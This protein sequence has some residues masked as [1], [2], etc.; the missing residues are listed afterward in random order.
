[1]QHIP[2]KLRSE[3]Q[4]R[5]GLPP[6]P[7]ALPGTPRKE[8]MAGLPQ[9]SCTGGGGQF[10]LEGSPPL[11]GSGPAGLQPAATVSKTVL[12][13]PGRRLARDIFFFFWVTLSRPNCRVLFKQPATNI[14]LTRSL[15]D[16][17]WKLFVLQPWVLAFE[18]CITKGC[19]GQRWRGE[20]SMWGAGGHSQGDHEP[21]P[22]PCKGVMLH[23]SFLPL[24]ST[25]GAAATVSVPPHR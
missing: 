2:S 5:Q 20:G 4:G 19:G 15:W 25:A 18:Q 6:V 22:R 13:W 1:M 16:E 24:L 9:G 3:A 11:G 17:K 10:P 21:G 12:R 7:T 8:H 14:F 23:T